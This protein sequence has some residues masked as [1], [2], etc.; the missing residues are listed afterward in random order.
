MPVYISG[1]TSPVFPLNVI[2]KTVESEICQNRTDNPPCG[3]PATVGD[4]LFPFLYFAFRNSTSILLFSGT[5]FINQLWSML[6]KHP[7]IS[8]S[9]THV[10]DVFCCKH[11]LMYEQ[12]SYADLNFLKPYE[13]RSP[14]VSENGSR[15]RSEA[16]AQAISM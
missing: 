1:F 2:F 11:N 14:V 8:A 3:T 5:C 16:R 7:L 9:S 15:V 4:N 10:A 12:A 13:C 6:S